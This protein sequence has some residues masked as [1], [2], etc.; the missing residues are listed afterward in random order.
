M[1]NP[2]FVDERTRLSPDIES[3]LV[4]LEG[5][6]QQDVNEL[7]QRLHHLAREM[8]M[9]NLRLLVGQSLDKVE[10]HGDVPP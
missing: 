10:A 3:R 6:Y 5:D 2:L 9:T 8:G 7:I 1:T 4:R